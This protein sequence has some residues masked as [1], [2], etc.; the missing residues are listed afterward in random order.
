[1]EKRRKD[2]RLRLCLPLCN[3]GPLTT[4]FRI[5][6]QTADQR[7]G[8]GPRKNFSCTWEGSTAPGCMVLGADRW[9]A[10]WSR[11]SRE[12]RGMTETLNPSLDSSGNAVFSTQIKVTVRRGLYWIT[13]SSLNS[14]LIA[15][16]RTEVIK[17]MSNVFKHICWW[18][19]VMSNL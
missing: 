1:M 7:G 12:S 16:E 4:Y 9:A 17:L 8:P 15:A 19:F 10:V 3:E 14:F 13:Q 11:C 2:G 5:T 6:Y 18:G